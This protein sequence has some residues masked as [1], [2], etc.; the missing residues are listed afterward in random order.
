VQ[1]GG[2]R[3]S[4]LRRASMWCCC[5]RVSS[6]VGGAALS[7]SACVMGFLACELPANERESGGKQGAAQIRVSKISGP[8]AL[9]KI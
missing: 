9:S 8:D 4:S 5:D 2:R 1:R 6:D 3:G 7:P